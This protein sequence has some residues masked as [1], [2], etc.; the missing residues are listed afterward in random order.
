MKRLLAIALAAASL[1]V[2]SAAS[3]AASDAESQKPIQ[4]DKVTITAPGLDLSPDPEADYIL[5]KQQIVFEYL[6]HDVPGSAI[7][8]AEGLQD[9]KEN[10]RPTYS[11]LDEFVAGVSREGWKIA[12]KRDLKDFYVVV[13]ATP[14]GNVAGE[15]YAKTH[16]GKKL[17]DSGK[18]QLFVS[19]GSF[20]QIVP[21]SQVFTLEQ[22]MRYAVYAGGELH[23]LAPA[24]FDDGRSFL[25]TGSFSKFVGWKIFHEGDLF[26]MPSGVNNFLFVFR[27][28]ATY[29]DGVVLKFSSRSRN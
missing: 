15:Y 10:W 27:G 24:N 16:E 28:G 23:G 20:R 26:M 25:S 4:L 19:D 22:R 14:H 2:R 6:G 3:D 8:Q 1:S 21:A 18:I 7:M 11:S 29:D 17:Q 12:A 13:F 5:P 9:L